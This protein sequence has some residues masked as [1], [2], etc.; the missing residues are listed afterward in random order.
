MRTVA[1]K[2]TVPSLALCL[3]IVAIRAPYHLRQTLTSARNAPSRGRLQH[4]LQYGPSRQLNGS[5]QLLGSYGAEGGTTR[6][7]L[8]LAPAGPRLRR[9]QNRPRDFV[10]W[11]RPHTLLRCSSLRPAE[12]T[13][14]KSSGRERDRHMDLDASHSACTPRN[15]CVTTAM[16]TPWL[17]HLPISCQNSRHGVRMH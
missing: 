12:R 6:L 9:V 8:S 1:V 13:S 14:R 5:T 16:L 2:L 7:L 3:R 4:G 11:V 10:R 17:R 15:S